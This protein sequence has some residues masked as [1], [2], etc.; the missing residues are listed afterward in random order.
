[1]SEVTEISHP[2]PVIHP[3]S[4]QLKM[5]DF[6]L[7]FSVTVQ[8]SVQQLVVLFT[9]NCTVSV[10]PTVQRAAEGQNVR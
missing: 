7:H 5:I 4:P 6:S 9:Q 8:Q 3:F 1:M 10:L 2:G